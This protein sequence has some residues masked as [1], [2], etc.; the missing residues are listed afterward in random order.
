MKTICTPQAKAALTAITA[1]READHLTLDRPALAALHPALIRHVLKLALTELRG[2]GEGLTYEHLEQI[3]EAAL[4]NARNVVSWTLPSP[5]S[6][7]KI[8]QK[9]VVLTLNAVPALFGDVTVP[10]S[11]PGT[12]ALPQTDW[13]VQASLAPLPDSSFTAV[14]DAD[15]VQGNT[16]TLRN[17]RHGDCIDPMGMNGRHKKVSDIFIDAKIPRTERLRVPIVADEAGILWIVGHCVAE[18]AKVT[19]ET[20]RRLYLAADFTTHPASV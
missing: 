13:R 19:P 7:V 1:E 6:T 9:T 4:A 17:W 18:R 8:T 5:A 12:A 10:L 3:S 14:L 2:T 20:R 11:I 16:L 15:T